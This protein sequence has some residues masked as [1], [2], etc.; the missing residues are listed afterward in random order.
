MPALLFICNI[1]A[2][3][4]GIAL[5]VAIIFM[6][7]NNLFFEEIKTS[8]KNSTASQWRKTAEGEYETIFVNDDGDEFHQVKNS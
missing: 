6:L 7:K 3:V 8:K 4:A 1:L 5:T 2:I